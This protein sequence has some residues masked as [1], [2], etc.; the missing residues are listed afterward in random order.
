MLKEKSLQEYLARAASGEEVPGGGSVSAVVSALGTSMAE[1]VG[2]FTVGKKKYAEF[3]E[4]VAG[5]LSS[6]AIIH[7]KLLDCVDRDAQAFLKFND[8][9]AMP[10]GSEEEKAVRDKAMQ[11]CLKGA[12]QP[13]MDVIRLSLEAMRLL[14]PLA[15]RGNTNL[16]TDVGVAGVGLIAGIKA[17][18]YNVLINLKWMKDE[19]EVEAR[20]D[21]IVLTLGEAYELASKVEMAVEAAL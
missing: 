11:E 4:E 2:N 3:E 15:E 19:V 16:I 21:E 7:E 1:M 17:A 14:P 10:K 18:R 5:I 9:Y 6:L 12:M 13:P 8:I 20:K